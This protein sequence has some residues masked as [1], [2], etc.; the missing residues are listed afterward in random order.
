MSFEFI[1]HLVDLPLQPGISGELI[2]HVDS[3]ELLLHA[4]DLGSHLGLLLCVLLQHPGHLGEETAG[5]G[6]CPP[7]PPSISLLPPAPGW[8]ALYLQS[9]ASLHVLGM[10]PTITAQ[11]KTPCRR[12]PCQLCLSF[13]CYSTNVRSLHFY[14]K[15]VIIEWTLIPP[16]ELHSGGKD[17]TSSSRP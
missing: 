4:L 10:L 16:P 13:S 6:S 11:I 7:P 5:S 12:V 1:R 9:L 15:T 8:A 14:C 17:P 3:G 2:H